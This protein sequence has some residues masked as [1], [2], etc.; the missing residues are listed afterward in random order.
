MHGESSGLQD[1]HQT[2]VAAVVAVAGVLAVGALRRLL[3]PPTAA[4]PKGAGA[5]S[6]NTDDLDS[7]YKQ[8]RRREAAMAEQEMAE[9][10]ALATGSRRDRTELEETLRQ[11][12]EVSGLLQQSLG[13]AQG[14]TAD[15]WGAMA[16]GLVD[17]REGGALD[18]D[19]E[20]EEEEE[21]EDGDKT[22]R[23]SRL[24]AA[25]AATRTWIDESDL[26]LAQA[27]AAPAMRTGASV[28]ET[29]AAAASLM[30]SPRQGSR[31]AAA[32]AVPSFTSSSESE[33]ESESGRRHAEPLPPSPVAVR[34]FVAWRV[35]SSAEARDRRLQASLRSALA[36]PSPS[37]GGSHNGGRLFAAPHSPAKST[38]SSVA[39]SV[40]SRRAASLPGPIMPPWTA[41]PAPPQPRTAARTGGDKSPTSS[42]VSTASEVLELEIARKNGRIANLEHNARQL[43]RRY[44]EAIAISSAGS[45]GTPAR[46]DPPPLH[47]Y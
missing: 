34:S 40:R 27:R 25:A 37:P 21:E 13:L 47:R 18:D 45:S 2:P 6:P 17:R 4:D 28:L 15:R 31:G 33:S 14:A 8:R 29:A 36:T 43:R 30:M 23:A 10:M 3:L 26:V 5:A 46:P 7:A 41:P 1:A 44:R 22:R 35:L 19:D 16:G 12:E 42:N 38:V 39:C 11:S 32:R 20:E 9:R 24:E